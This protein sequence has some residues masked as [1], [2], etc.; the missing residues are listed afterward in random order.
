MKQPE[1]I[2]GP[3]ALENFKEFGRM[4]LQAPARKKKRNLFACPF[5]NPAQR[6]YGRMG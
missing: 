2:E 1:Y 3:K 4:I 5:H 6:V